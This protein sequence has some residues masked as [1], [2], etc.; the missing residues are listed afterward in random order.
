VKY[1]V[2]GADGFLGRHF[3]AEIARRGVPVRAMLA[4]G[5]PAKPLP[6]DPQIVRA[7]LM[8]WVTLETAVEGVTDI[9]HLAARVHVL[10]DHAQDPDRAFFQVN[11]EGTRA[12]LEAAERAGVKRFLLMSSVAAM[13]EEQ[14]GHSDQSTSDH[15]ST[16]YGR[17][18]R[19]AEQVMFDLAGKCGIDAVAL[20]PP[21]IYGPGAKG[22]VLSLLDAAYTDRRLP[23]G[24][25]SN[26]R[27]MVYVGTVIDAALRAIESP[28]SAGKTYIVCDARPY[29]T[30]ELYSEICR[31]MGKP[32]LLRNVPVWLLTAAA[33]IGDVAEKLLHR[34]MPVDSYVVKRIVGDLC[35]DGS[36]IQQELGWSPK[37][38]L[39]EGIQR[40]VQWYL[41]GCPPTPPA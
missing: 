3:L 7:D 15:A 6:G 30:A 25:I 29:G 14:T 39:E 13:G 33:M 41:Q 9:I 32:P 21:I 28:V 1:L 40:T 11:V 27:S 35:F 31:A 16:P 8:D 10:D 37:V 20:R 2:T 26:Q 36:K 17:S 5:L 19:A 38:S 24:R 4:P 23:F 18:K 12:L 34:K 22:N